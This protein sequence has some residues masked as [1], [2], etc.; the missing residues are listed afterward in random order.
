[1]VTR[2]YI[3]N[4]TPFVSLLIVGLLFISNGLTL[5]FEGLSDE[6]LLFP[7]DIKQVGK[8]YKLLTYPF[9]V[10]GLAQWLHSAIVILMSGYVLERRLTK[11][12]VIGLM[13]LSSITGGLIFSLIKVN[14]LA[15]NVPI[16][17]PT[18]ITWGVSSCAFV[19]VIKQIK[20]STL[21]DKIVAGLYLVSLL[22][23]DFIDLGFAMG[24]VAVI[25]LG[26]AYGLA[27]GRIKENATSSDFAKSWLDE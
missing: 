19:L 15:L 10:G 20:A 25:L 26:L 2:A 21:L 17:S 12:K 8:W 5:L 11:E 24:Q 18:M 1:M 23:M 13:A 7:Q 16:A 4:N 27:F 9:Y 3:N 14:T 6:F 22:S